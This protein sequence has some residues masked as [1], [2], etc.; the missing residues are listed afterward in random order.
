MK[1][2]VV[3]VCYNAAEYIAQTIESV[4][5]QSWPELEYIIVDGGSTDWTLDIIGRYATD[6]RLRW[7]SEP[8]EGIADAMN[9]GA[10]LATGDVIAH[11]NADDYY[12][13]PDVLARVVACFQ[14]H[15]QALWLTGGFNF[16]SANKLLLR[17]IRVRSYSFQRL[18]R[19]NIILHP[20][21]FLKREAFW[22]AGGF[23]IE[24]KYCMDYDLFLRM[25]VLAPPVLLD[26]QLSCFRVHGNSRTIMDAERAYAEEYRVRSRFLRDNDRGTFFFALDYQ[27]KKRLNR[28]FY[29]RL[30]AAGKNGDN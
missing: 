13:Q 2:T 16:V 28:W 4:L 23:D 25:A 1:I 5:G 26:E 30:F 15:P 14:E 8:D 17:K 29:R 7:V 24:L 22:Q 19:G 10:R 20:S 3:T 11:L 27:V 6:S 21:T 18:V 9:K 12:A